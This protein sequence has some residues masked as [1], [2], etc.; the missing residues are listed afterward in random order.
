MTVQYCWSGPVYSRNEFL[1]E[2]LFCCFFLHPCFFEQQLYWWAVTWLS[3]WWCG[4]V[5]PVCW[6]CSCS[7]SVCSLNSLWFSVESKYY[8]S[9]SEEHSQTCSLVVCIWCWPC[10]FTLWLLLSRIMQHEIYQSTER[11]DFV[12]F[13]VFSF[14]FKNKTTNLRCLLSFFLSRGCYS[15]W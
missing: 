11:S 7:T 13:S 14:T 4:P 3:Q 9:L 8:I 15:P 5:Q 1:D 2:W 10:Q 12:P 6:K